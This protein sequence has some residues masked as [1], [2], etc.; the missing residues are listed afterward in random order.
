MKMQQ[1]GT[2]WTDTAGQPIQAHGGQIIVADGYYYWYGEDRRENRYVACY[3]STDLAQWEFRNYVLTTDS[4]TAAIRQRTDLRL[5][6]DDGGKVNI[7]RPKVLYCPQTGRYVMWAH[8]ENGRNYDDARACIASCDTPD[9]DFVYHGSFNPYGHMSRDCTLFR[10]DDGKAYFLSAARDNLDLNI[11]LLTDDYLNVR[12]HVNTL[13]QGELREA[14]AV[15]KRDGRYY[16]LTSWCT[17]WAPNQGKFGVGDSMDGL[18][19]ELRDFGDETTFRSQPAF[20]LPVSHGCTTEYL[21]F[22]DRWCWAP[23]DLPPEERDRRMMEFYTQSSYVV[24]PIRFR[25]GAPYIVY[26]AQ[27]ELG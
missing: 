21:Y 16:I 10:D 13:W 4:P 14:P 18:F 2:V 26:E 23:K 11:Y 3:R 12:R 25:G 5:V 24:L 20:V 9:G 17:G 19:T 15:F 22:A 1:N 6:R 8:Y 27:T 7:E